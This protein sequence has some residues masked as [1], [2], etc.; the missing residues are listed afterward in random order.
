MTSARFVREAQAKTPHN[1]D[2]QGRQ[3][4]PCVAPLHLLGE[5]TYGVIRNNRGN[6]GEERSGFFSASGHNRIYSELY[7][8]KA[9]LHIGAIVHQIKK[10]IEV[11]FMC[12]KGP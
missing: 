1:L 9:L 2:A 10:L 8:G 12:K 5:D 4:P 7:I 3:N 11:A 6:M